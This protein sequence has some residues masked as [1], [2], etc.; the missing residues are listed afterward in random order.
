M[1]PVSA[2]N[3]Q[4]ILGKSAFMPWYD[5]PALLPYLEQI[6][7]GEDRS[8]LPLRFPV[9]W[10]NR[11][12]RDFRGLAGTL[13]SGSLKLGDDVLVAHSRKPAKI[14]RI[15]TM[16]G[17]LD[18]IQPGQAVTLILDLEL[19]ISRGDMLTPPGATPEV[20][21]TASFRRA[22]SGCMRSLPIPDA[23]TC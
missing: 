2:L 7:T 20:P 17:D 14:E 4:N 18:E 10:V 15:V 13:A 6:E 1:I 11:A 16:G 21:P 3:G 12:S 5:G 23:L 22:L 19:D 8:H 9:Q